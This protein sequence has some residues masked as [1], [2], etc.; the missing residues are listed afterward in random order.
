MSKG[1]EAAGLITGI[2]ILLLWARRHKDLAGH[3]LVILAAGAVS[4]LVIPRVPGS[5]TACLINDSCTQARAGWLIGTIILLPL[6]CAAVLN[7]YQVYVR[8]G[9]R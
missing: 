6:G 9:V 1:A 3:I 7:L 8:G 2:G 5:P 4:W